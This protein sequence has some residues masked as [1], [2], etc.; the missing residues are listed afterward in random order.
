MSD[1]E[2]KDQQLLDHN[3]NYNQNEEL[4][5]TEDVDENGWCT[6]RSKFYVEKY[7]NSVLYIGR[8]FK[9]IKKYENKTLFD[10]E[11]FSTSQIVAVVTKQN[12]KTNQLYF[13]FCYYHP[14]KD[15]VTT[16]TSTAIEYGYI[17]CSKMMS[18]D[19]KIRMVEFEALNGAKKFI[20]TCLIGRRISKP[21]K[22]SLITAS[23]NITS[24]QFFSGFIKS[25]DSKTKLY[26]IH[27]PDDDDEEDLYEKELLKYLKA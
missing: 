23:S 6:K 11:K 17:L 20:G 12:D 1:D 9:V 26:H 21:F 7:G 25:F 22:K 27:Y 4:T 5:D 10:S 15:I 18:G 16:N 8:I 13:K 24:I 2:K 3:Q 14:N 19:E